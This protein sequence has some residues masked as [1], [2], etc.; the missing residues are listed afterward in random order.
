MKYV[1]SVLI[2]LLLINCNAAASDSEALFVA[3]CAGCH[4]TNGKGGRTSKMHVADLSSKPVQQLSDDQLYDTIAKGTQHK[5]YPHAYEYQGLKKDQI[6]GL[7]AYI[8][9]LAK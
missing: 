6:K 9:K 3:K 4:G 2:I 1:F 7:V 8:R 5:E